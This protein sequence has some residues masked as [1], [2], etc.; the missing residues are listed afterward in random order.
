MTFPKRSAIFWHN[1][2]KED[3]MVKNPL[4]SFVVVTHDRPFE[5]VKKR[6][7]KSIACQ[8]YSNKELIIIGEDRPSVQQLA[9]EVQKKLKF[10]QVRWKNIPRSKKETEKCI[11]ERVAVC[12]NAGISLAHGEFISCQDDDNELENDFTSSLL[13]IINSK[14]EDAAWSYRK[15]VMPDG[16]PFLG[17]F[18]P[19]VDNDPIRRRIL[20]QI[21]KDARIFQP[22]SDIIRDQLCAKRNSEQFSTVDPNEW[23]VRASVFRQIPYRERYNYLAIS[24]N[25]TFDDLWNID[26]CNAG[27]NAV[28]SKKVGLIYY[29]GG[30]S[31]TIPDSGQI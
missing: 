21:W 24:Y 18:F 9:D 14:T 7:I 26:I 12:R 27:V 11:W 19:W 5:L 25:I 6:I 3:E 30:L 8:N 29:L 15:A 16:S 28:C 22:G 20:Y 1:L 4:V 2:A 10:E 31:N 23:L 13:K 17:N